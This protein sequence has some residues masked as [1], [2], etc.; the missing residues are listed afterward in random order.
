SGIAERRLFDVEDARVAREAR[1]QVLRSLKHEIP[2]K[3][4]K[5]DDVPERIDGSGSVRVW[6]DF[7]HR[8]EFIKKCTGCGLR[9]QPV[10]QGRYIVMGMR[11]SPACL[12][13]QG[14]LMVTA[15]R[16][17]PARRSQNSP[18]PPEAT[19]CLRR[20]SWRRGRS[21]HD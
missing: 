21:T 3:V 18:A 15:G 8:P 6:L 11:A 16:S 9:P 10:L 14:H 20:D 1:E 2:A 7:A 5:A 19:S 13:L 17:I 12:L 4:G